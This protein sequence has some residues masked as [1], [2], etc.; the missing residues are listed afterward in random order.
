MFAKKEFEYDTGKYLVY[1][2]LE[3]GLAENTII[4]YKQEL[5]KFAA[6]LDKKKLR[7]TGISETD[8]VNFIKDEAVKG[9]S[10]ATQSHLI[11]V[12][13]S[14]YKYLIAEDKIDFNPAANISFPKK[15]K[16]LP[17][18][19]TMDQV[20]ALLDLPGTGKPMGLRDKAILELMYATGLRISEV[21]GLKLDNIYLDDSFLRVM[22]KGGK[23]R[24]VPFGEKAEQCVK[25]YMHHGRSKLLKQKQN[26]FVFLNRNGEQLSRQGLWK[27][28]KGYGKKLGISTNLTPHTLRHSFATH[29]LE[30]G[31][32]LR[33]IQMMLG[34]SSISTTEIYTYVAKHRV[35]KIYDKFHP[36]GPA[37]GHPH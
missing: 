31:A 15:W 2:Q 22:G 14:F 10:L 4:S 11:S 33:S 8:T 36:R 16:V 1:L 25:D 32:D 21:T 20:G 3:R 7:H 26:D 24:V 12:L 13:K 18:Y 17:K 23:E 19:L 30:K 37:G 9:N 35:K 28:I 29:L 27:I 5:E 34:H 6:Y